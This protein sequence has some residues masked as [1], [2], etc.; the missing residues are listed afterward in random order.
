MNLQKI[1]EP[2]D[3][4]SCETT[5]GTSDGFILL[6]ISRAYG[7][8]FSPV[9]VRNVKPLS[10]LTAPLGHFSR[11]SIIWCSQI[12]NLSRVFGLKISKELTV[13]RITHQPPGH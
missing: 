7:G 4:H 13:V 9:H 12:R 10:I 1:P 6:D 5:M 11:G 3:G 8:V 2:P